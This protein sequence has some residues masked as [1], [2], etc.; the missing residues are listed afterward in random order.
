MTYPLE[1]LFRPAVERHAA[2]AALAAASGVIAWPEV[3]MLTPGAGL[4]VAALLFAHALRREAQAERVLRFQRHL[5]QPP[6]YVLAAERIP[7]SRYKL[8]LGRGFRWTAVH[9][10]RLID[11]RRPEYAHFREA[12]RLYRLARRF[13]LRHEHTGLA[14]ATALTRRPA[15]W[16]P[17]APM[18][19]VGGDPAL[20]GVEPDEG[21]VYLALAERVGHMVVV[22]TT[23]TGKSRFLE[24]LVAQDIRRGET[25]IVFD[26]KGDADV[27]R[28]VYAEAK[29]TGRIAQFHF[30]H[31]GYPQCSARYNPI[32]DFARIT[33]VATRIANNMPSGG[34]AES[35]KQFVWKYVN[36][37]VRAMVALGRKPSYRALHRYAENFE[38]LILDYFMHWLDREPLAA[39]W[40]DEV[41]GIEIDNARLDKALKSRGGELVKLLDYAKRKQLYDS[42]ASALASVV[43]YENSYFQKLVA[44]LYPFL[45]KVTTGEIADLVS[46]DYENLADPRPIF[47][48]MT[49]LNNGGI[50][51]VGLDSLEDPAVAT[52]VGNAMF[53]D[54][55]SVAGK[56]Y[57]HGLGYGQVEEVRPR[58]LAIHADEFNDLIGDEF[59]PMVNK[60]GGAG[61]Q[62][63]AYTQTWADVEARIGNRAKAEQIEGNFNSRVF[64][65][66]VN[67]KTAE[68]ITRKLHEVRL[69]TLIAASS[70]TDTNDPSDFAEFASRNEDRIA[71][72]RVPMLTPADLVNLPKGQ[73]FALIDGGQLYKIRMPLPDSASDPAMPRDFAEMARDMVQRYRAHQDPASAPGLT[74]E[75]KGSGF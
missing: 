38:P 5:R 16:N 21:D 54:L 72:E 28:R 59:I 68:I 24:L 7:W 9:T 63:T 29:R 6:H 46:P 19:E 74:V 41:A 65:R 47:D 52:A 56:V 3:L 4:I 44:S 26:P 55:T 67:E 14:W 11:S 43:T 18:P 2:I 35:F 53:A 62:V 40:R 32:G 17:V 27:F 69:T 36:G 39:G 60:A 64:L 61:Y 37:L 34:D 31:L 8:F 75:G 66:V 51:Y 23:R 25:V 70:A 1:N 12:S 48:W 15:R 57:K 22:G 33:E 20:H 10:Q 13:E 50:V 73:A 71:S 49:I 42:T 45:E 30:F 58:R